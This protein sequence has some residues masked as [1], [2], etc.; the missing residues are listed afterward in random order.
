MSVLKEWRCEQHGPFEGSHAICPNFGCRSTEV[1]RVFLTPVSIGSSFVKRHERGVANLAEAYG[2]TNWKTAREGENSKVLATGPEMLWGTD[3][4]KKLGMD[5]NALT[6]RTAQPFT[7]EHKDGSRETVPHGMP[8][9]ARE[10][11]LTQN[12]LPPAGELTVSAGEQKMKKAI[13]A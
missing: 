4:Q 1:S 10:L 12:V 8:M 2:Q 11:G 3:V 13:G 5:M 7:V 9:V 6:A